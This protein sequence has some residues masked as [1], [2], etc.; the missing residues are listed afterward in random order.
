MQ[1]PKPTL[2]PGPLLDSPAEP[3]R[4]RP[5][6]RLRSI[7]VGNLRRMA[8]RLLPV[9]LLL[10]PTAALAQAAESEAAVPGK[11]VSEKG[12]SHWAIALHGGAG[13]IPKDMPEEESREYFA[14][15]EKALRRGA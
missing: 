7:P 11:A 6:R 15:L 9:A 14:A 5:L 10:L 3:L 8:R 13:V 12:E 1:S 2:P 4:S